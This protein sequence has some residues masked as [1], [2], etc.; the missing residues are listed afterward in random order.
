[1][2]RRLPALVAALWWGSLT[3]IGFLVVPLLFAYLPSP[4]VAGN[5]AARLFTAQ[6]WVAVAC[7]LVLL[8]MPKREVDRSVPVELP[9]RLAKLVIEQREPPQVVGTVAR[10]DGEPGVQQ[11]VRLFKEG[12]VVGRQH[13]HRLGGLV[14]QGPRVVA[15]QHEREGAEPEGMAVDFHLREGV[16]ERLHRGRR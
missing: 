11:V 1:M 13:L 15:V 9:P 4:S 3:T 14:P 6:T 12:A 7:C 10:H 2:H 5:M 16:T 8:L